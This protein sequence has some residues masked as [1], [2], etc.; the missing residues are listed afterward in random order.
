MLRLIGP[1]LDMVVND[2]CYHKP[3]YGLIQSKASPFRK[4]FTKNVYDLAFTRLIE[5]IEKETW[6]FG[7]IITRPVQNYYTITLKQ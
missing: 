7:K 3:L 6:I 1:G 5:Q 2:I 4:I